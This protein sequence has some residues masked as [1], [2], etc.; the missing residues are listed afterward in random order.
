MNPSGNPNAAAAA[1]P[2]LAAV[3]Q[4][5]EVCGNEYDHLMEIRQDG[6]VRR[7]DS[8]ECAIAGMAPRC[9]HCKCAI[10]GHGVANEEGQVFCC[11]N[12]LRQVGSA[13]LSA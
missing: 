12:C 11:A 13:A 10:I 8:F 7:F 6:K 3:P 1:S 9:T 4:A 5:C 2:G